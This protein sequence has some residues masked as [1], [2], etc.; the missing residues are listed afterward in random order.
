MRSEMVTGPLKIYIG[1]VFSV[2]CRLTFGHV[3]F[4]E[5]MNSGLLP[6]S[7]PLEYKC[8]LRI[9]RDVQR[10]FVQTDNAVRKKEPTTPHIQAQYWLIFSNIP[11]QKP[12]VMSRI[13]VTSGSFVELLNL[14]LVDFLSFFLL[15]LQK[16]NY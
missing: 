8:L 6:W 2:A 14:L 3:E 5:L 1:R 11:L 15:F 4:V 12:F 7:V 13:F 9:L 16:K 10:N